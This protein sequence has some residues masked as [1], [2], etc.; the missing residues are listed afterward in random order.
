MN[1]TNVPVSPAKKSKSDRWIKIAFLVLLI[2]GAAGIYLFQQR[3]LS[4][5]GWGSDLAAALAQ[6]QAENRK[7]VAIFVADPP[8]QIA[9]T[10]GGEVVTRP[11][12]RQAVEEGEFLPVVVSLDG[13]LEHPYAQ[14]YQLTQLPTLMVIFPDGT[15]RNRFEGRIGEIEFR[16]QFLQHTPR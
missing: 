8:S 11:D 2:A 1:P 3:A 15:E 14:T 12:N 13:G 9:R 7:I 10:I 4:I 6:A 16:S 5:S